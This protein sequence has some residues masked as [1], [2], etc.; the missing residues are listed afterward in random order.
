MLPVDRGF[1]RRYKHKNEAVHCDIS[2]ETGHLFR[3]RRRAGDGVYFSVL[4]KPAQGDPM[5]GMWSITLQGQC[6]CIQ[7]KK[8]PYTKRNECG[9]SPPSWLMSS[10]PVRCLISVNRKDGNNRNS[11]LC[12]LWRKHSLTTSYP[13]SETSGSS[14]EVTYVVGRTLKYVQ[15]CGFGLFYFRWRAEGSI[16][17]YMLSWRCRWVIRVLDLACMNVGST[18]STAKK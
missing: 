18:F 15:I 5:S 7:M 6:C 3:S 14:H 12:I 11:L 9:L 16:D 1:F 13:W 4:T 17:V 8:E 10:L 2:P